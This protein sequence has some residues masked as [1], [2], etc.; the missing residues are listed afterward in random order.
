MNR[1]KAWLLLLLGLVI[2]ALVILAAGL[3][4]LRF[5]PGEPLPLTGILQVLTETQLSLPGVTLPFNIVRP[6][7]AC[8]WLLLIASIIGFII[9]P[10][11]RKE[12]FKRVITYSLWIILFYYLITSL[13]PFLASLASQ[14]EQAGPGGNELPDALEPIEQLPA[15]PNF[16]ADPP[17]WLIIIITILIIGLVLGILW[18]LWRF[19]FAPKR[20][21]EPLQLLTN[22][23]Q[24][25]LNDIQ[26]GHDLKDAI[27]RCYFEMSRILSQQRHLQRPQGM[28][29]RE[30]EQFLAES[31]LQTEHIKRLTRLFETVRYSN[32][33]P[34]RRAELEAVDCLS[35]IV[36]TYGNPS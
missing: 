21:S 5:H 24:Q 16:V 25:A 8:V 23:A 2:M 32:T 26:A 22:E 34:N 10:E 29:P 14:T 31:G 33:P 35:A 11:I 4:I 20:R 17:Q 18:L 19:F 36:T 1:K 30:F 6:L 27:K 12:V 7:I 3:P 15:P 9:S 28:T 13:Q